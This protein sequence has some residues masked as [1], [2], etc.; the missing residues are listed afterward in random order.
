MNSDTYFHL[1][2]FLKKVADL[3]PCFVR[4]HGPWACAKTNKQSKEQA[5]RSVI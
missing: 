4:L 1:F 2:Y 5:D 3:L